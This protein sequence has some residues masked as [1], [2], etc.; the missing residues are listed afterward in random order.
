LF[1][2]IAQVW[3]KHEKRVFTIDN[4]FVIKKNVH[5]SSD[6]VYMVDILFAKTQAI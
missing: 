4:V 5:N 1:F 2:K 3:G 6:F